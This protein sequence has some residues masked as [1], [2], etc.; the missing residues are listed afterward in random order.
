MPK[1]RGPGPPSSRPPLKTLRDHR[2]LWR[3]LQEQSAAGTTAAGSRPKTRP[4][5][6]GSGPCRSYSRRTAPYRLS[7]VF[8]SSRCADVPHTGSQ[9]DVP[10]RAPQRIPRRCVTA[11][12]PRC[13][14][15]SWGGPR[16]TPAGCRRRQRKPLRLSAGPVCHRPY[17]L[18]P[19]RPCPPPVVGVEPAGPPL[20]ADAHLDID[21]VVPVDVHAE[22]G[23]G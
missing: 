22:D 21:V 18:P 9:Q 10:R 13:R 20:A 5:H 2:P 17:D 1:S 12:R 11:D 3:R 16:L 6:V 19:A 15:S 14:G 4:P 7:I 8:P 23:R